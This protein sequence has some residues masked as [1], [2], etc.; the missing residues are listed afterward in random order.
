MR[1]SPDHTG[2]SSYFYSSPGGVT[3]DYCSLITMHHLTE[4]ITN[5]EHLRHKFLGV[6]QDNEFGI[7]RGAQLTKLLPLHIFPGIEYRY[8]CDVSYSQNCI[9]KPYAKY[10]SWN[11]CLGMHNA[12]RAH[13]WHFLSK[14]IFYDLVPALCY[15]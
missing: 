4:C 8:E 3:K 12:Q 5:F 14:I 11:C 13:K 2:L 6:I 7:F 1:G 9:F 15:T 10:V